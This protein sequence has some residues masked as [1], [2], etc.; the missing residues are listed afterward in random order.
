MSGPVLETR[1]LVVAPLGADA[2][3]IREVLAEAG[4]ATVICR[5][6]GAAA[7]GLAEGCG[8]L[9][10]TEESMDSPL[11]TLLSAQL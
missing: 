11:H 2:A 7:S 6:I 3:N 5:D 9:L 1:V 4:F 8:V 10:V